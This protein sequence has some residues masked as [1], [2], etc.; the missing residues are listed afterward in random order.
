MLWVDQFRPKQFSE[1]S[2]HNDLTEKLKK[3]V[4]KGNFPH[5]LFYGPNGAG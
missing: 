4:E 5:L 2:Y 3:M 1:L